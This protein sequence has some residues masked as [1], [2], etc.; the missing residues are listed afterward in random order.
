MGDEWR[1]RHTKE[2][3]GNAATLR[4]HKSAELAAVADERER[5]RADKALRAKAARAALLPIARR[6][7]EEV[8]LERHAVASAMRAERDAMLHRDIADELKGFD[9]A[10]KDQLVKISEMLNR[11]MKTLSSDPL[12]C[13]WIKVSDRAN[14]WTT[15]TTVTH[16]SRH[17]DCSFGLRRGQF[18]V[19]AS[20]GRRGGGAAG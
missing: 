9:P 12:S 8:R 10:P 14:R 13:S 20:A 17:A 1:T 18:G 15:V 2:K 16:D 5:D 7:A 6:V 4:Q 3:I 19:G 11:A